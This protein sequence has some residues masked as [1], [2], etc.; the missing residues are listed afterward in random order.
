[1]ASFDT[2]ISVAAVS[3]GVLSSLCIHAGITTFEQTL[4]L[5]LLGTLA[6]L[7]PDIDSDSSTSLNLL[8]HMG[9]FALL[10][11]LSFHRWNDLPLTYLW[12][13]ALAL[14]GVLRFV[15]LPTFTRITDHRGHCHSLLATLVFA[16]GAVVFCYQLLGTG[17]ALSWLA[18][19]FTAVGVLTH[20]LL[21]EWAAIDWR[22][23]S[24]KKSLGTALKPVRLGDYPVL[25]LLLGA[26][27]GLWWLAPAYE[28]ALRLYGEL[29]LRLS[30]PWYG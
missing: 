27:T 6:G 12:G 22:G 19:L 14:Y 8:F 23:L 9:Y 4:L 30:H 13:A 16:L 17:A 3:S 24:L 18:G 1:M 28:P 20:L 15:A 29:W 2:H 26:L 21:D 7:L 11:W 10:S 25:V 5:W